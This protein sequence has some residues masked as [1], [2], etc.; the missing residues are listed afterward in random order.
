VKHRTEQVYDDEMSPL[1][2]Q[3]IDI[4]KREGIPLFV[5]AALFNP[6]GSRLSCETK[7][8]GSLPENKGMNNRH[9]LAMNLVRSHDGMDTAAGLMITRHHAEEEGP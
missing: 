5:S 7:I 2:A 4:A 6:D 8:P 3:L 9:A 1:V